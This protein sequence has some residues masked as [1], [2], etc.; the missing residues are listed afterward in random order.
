M[1]ELIVKLVT[2][3]A[4][5]VILNGEVVYQTGDVKSIVRYCKNHFG[6]DIPTKV[7]YYIITARGCGIATKHEGRHS[8]KTWISK[9]HKPLP[10]VDGVIPST[11]VKT[12]GIRQG[13][14]GESYKW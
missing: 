4:Y 9:T 12:R 10:M 11:Q 3:H 5:G 14:L 2:T 7:C 8:A 1:K 13:H 6:I